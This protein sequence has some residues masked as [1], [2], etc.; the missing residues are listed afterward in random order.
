MSLRVRTGLVA[1]V[2]GVAVV[3][4]GCGSSGSSD[5]ASAVEITGAW[6]RTSQPKV[7]D[8]AVYLK[9]LSHQTDHLT[10]AR[11]DPSVAASVELHET[12][13]VDGSAI[14]STNGSVGGS[15][16]NMPGMSDQSMDDDSSSPADGA[17]NDSVPPAEKAM[18]MRPVPGG[19]AVPSGQALVLSP[20]G[21]HLMLTGLAKPLEAGQSFPLVLSFQRSGDQTVTVEVRND[22]P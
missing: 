11:V 22:A 14:V 6:A 2:A 10:T 7:T 4:A 12:V 15:Q 16:M 8:G 18:T 3:V 5:T 1:V 19:L 13:S 21:Y 9:I 20:G 17:Q